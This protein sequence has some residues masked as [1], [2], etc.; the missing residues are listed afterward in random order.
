[1]LGK[2]VIG[3][4]NQCNLYYSYVNVVIT[5][6]TNSLQK[7]MRHAQPNNSS[8]TSPLY[9]AALQRDDEH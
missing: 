3:I 7:L 8:P 9:N 2:V 5:P 1:M 4:Y 6:S